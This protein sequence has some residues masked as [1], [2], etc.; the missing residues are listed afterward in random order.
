MSI[1]Q[2]RNLSFREGNR[3]EETQL[4]SGIKQ[5]SILSFEICKD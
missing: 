4:I 1:L 2:T 5:N 3:P